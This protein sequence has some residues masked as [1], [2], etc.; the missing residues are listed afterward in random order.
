MLVQRKTI[1]VDSV[2]AV[3]MT[4]SVPNAEV[5]EIGQLSLP[6]NSARKPDSAVEMTNAAGRRCEELSGKWCLGETSDQTL[7]QPEKICRFHQISLF[8]GIPSVS[9]DHIISQYTTIYHKRI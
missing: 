5:C 4:P 6:G 7:D 9:I 1:F 3:S 2:V 8:C